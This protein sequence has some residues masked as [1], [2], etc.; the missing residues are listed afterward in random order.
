MSGARTHLDIDPT[1]CGELVELAVGF[2]RTRLR[3]SDRM[4]VDARGLV[5]G[6]FVFGLADYAAMLA[7]NDPFVVLG[8]ADVKFVAPIV[9]GDEVEATA[10]IVEEKG[11]KRVVQTEATV[12][13]R[14]VFAG[15]FTT[16]VLEAHV[17][18]G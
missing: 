12:A 6:S 4:R 9:V 8:A 13:G 15:T 10:T 11:K 17:L 18:D 16:F 7:V 1:L 2:A 14:V 3:A 5:H